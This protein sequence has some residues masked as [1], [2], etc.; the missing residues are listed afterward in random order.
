MRK[1]SKFL[2]VVA[3]AS[4]SFLALNSFAN[5]DECIDGFVR[6]SGNASKI[7]ADLSSFQKATP[8]VNGGI[9]PGSKILNQKY[10]EIC[11]A[12]GFNELVDQNLH[13]NTG[14][15]LETSP[16]HNG[17]WHFYFQ[18]KEHP[19]Y[20]AKLAGRV[21]RGEISLEEAS[22]E[23]VLMMRLRPNSR[24]AAQAEFVV[25]SGSDEPT[26]LNEAKLIGLVPQTLFDRPITSNNQALTLVAS[27][28]DLVGSILN[29]PNR[30]SIFNG[31]DSDGINTPLYQLMTD[32]LSPVLNASSANKHLPYRP[33]D[34]FVHTDGNSYTPLSFMKSVAQF[35]PN[36][37]VDV[38][39]TS[40]NQ[41]LLES[42]I[43]ASLTLPKPIPVPVGFAIYNQQ[44]FQSSGVASSD[45]VLQG[46][47]KLAGGH[48]VLIE[49]TRTLDAAFAGAVFKNS[50]DLQG[51]DANGNQPSNPSLSGYNGITPGYLLYTILQHEP[52]DFLFH[53]SVVNQNSPFSALLKNQQ[54]N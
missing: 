49:N 3:F 5:G 1:T 14:V 26:A 20:F 11:W 43:Q 23:A 24:A 17:F 33:N 54:N 34:Q 4:I 45:L 51:L 9:A 16:D 50:W 30:T 10:A 6:Y 36:S 32:K 53:I 42:A 19:M 44:G 37:F 21:K 13:T 39:M 29:A 52:P 22:L 25:H 40:A 8:L 7:S 2:S 31:V 38:Q 18:I 48:L 41:K 28:K 47:V 46:Q 27:L 15:T 35:D 12:Y